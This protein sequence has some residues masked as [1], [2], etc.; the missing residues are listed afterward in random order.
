MSF[1][2]LFL[3]K[4]GSAMVQHWLGDCKGS[5]VLLEAKATLMLHKQ[6]GCAHLK[7]TLKE[8]C[9]VKTTFNRSTG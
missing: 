9:R 5:L 2:V 4:N 8:T 7:P 3:C 6:S 1:D